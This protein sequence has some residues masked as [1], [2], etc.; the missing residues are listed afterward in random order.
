[1]EDLWTINNHLFVQDSISLDSTKPSRE[2]PQKGLSMAYEP[3]NH[4]GLILT[5]Y[6]GRGHLAEGL[7]LNELI[8]SSLASRKI[9]AGAAAAIDPC[10]WIKQVRGL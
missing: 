3:E 4:Q 6:V 7:N 10:W 2:P 9:M 5:I 8:V 1:M